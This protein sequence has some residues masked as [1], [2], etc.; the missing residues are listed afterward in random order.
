MPTEFNDRDHVESVKG[1][2]T[3]TDE[4]GL[5]KPVPH[6]SPKFDAEH[7]GYE[8]TDV[9]TK[10]VVV[11]IGGLLGF[12]FVFFILCYAMG[13][14]INYGLLK[15]DV[16]QASKNPLAAAS[17]EA[18]QKRGASLATNP[19][20]EQADAAK[21]AS[22]F[23]NPRPPSDDDNAETSDMHAREDLLLEHY[24][25]ADLSEG[26][27]GTIH[28]PI[29]RAMQ[30]I[31]KRGLPTAATPATAVQTRLTGDTQA[32]VKAP[33]T[34]GFARTGYELDQIESR[35]QKMKLGENPGEKTEKK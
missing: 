16:D 8:T 26:S 2:S 33:L 24:T 27:D 5:S 21:I 19:E 32:D 6:E 29:E 30:L 35:D 18:I 22:S 25:K 34:T 9:N 20:Q 28:I 12:L 7:P 17:P 11:F 15:Q 31:V 14:A 23:P 4:H 1:P 13:K 3:F 10:N